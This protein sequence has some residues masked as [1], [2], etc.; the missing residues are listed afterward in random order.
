[1]L[2]G[3][4]APAAGRAHRDGGRVCRSSPSW[5][6]RAGTCEGSCGH[7]VPSCRTSS[8]PPSSVSAVRRSAA[9]PRTTKRSPSTRTRHRLWLTRTPSQPS[10]RRCSTSALARHQ[11]L[12]VGLCDASSQMRGLVLH[13]VDR[14]LHLLLALSYAHAVCAFCE[15]GV[16]CTSA[17]VVTGA[18]S[19]PQQSEQSTSTAVQRGG[20]PSY[21]VEVSSSAPAADAGGPPDISWDVGASTEADTEPASIDWGIDMSSASATEPAEAATG[22]SWDVEA[23]PPSAADAADGA[24]GISWD[25]DMDAAGVSTTGD[26]AA[27]SGAGAPADIDWGLEVADEGAGGAG[28]GEGISIDW[29]VGDDGGAGGAGPSVP[30]AADE[31]SSHSTCASGVTAAIIADSDFRNRLLPLLSSRRARLRHFGNTACKAERNGQASPGRGLPAH[32]MA[33]DAQ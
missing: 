26:A 32:E 1:V 8:S 17:D 31:D 30:E 22:I 5:A 3:D 2:T 15:R 11:D 12:Q 24:A 29:D 33:P 7:L 21:D 13:V 14:A 28:G 19:V 18:E 27:A 6:L 10:C 23:E 9:P 4:E 16:T 20:D 25:I